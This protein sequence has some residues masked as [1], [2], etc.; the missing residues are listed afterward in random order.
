MKSHSKRQLKI[1]LDKL[2]RSE[3]YPLLDQQSSLISQPYDRFLAFSEVF[4]F[5]KVFDF[6]E[7]FAFPEV[8]ALHSFTVHTQLSERS[9]T[10]G[11]VVP[12][13]TLTARWTL[14][15]CCCSAAP[16]PA[17]AAWPRCSSSRSPPRC[18]QPLPVCASPS[19]SPPRAFFS[20]SSVCFGTTP[21]T[22]WFWLLLMKD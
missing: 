7:V 14:P 2:V 4:A 5:P 18:P 15:G 12:A 19:P 17:A 8:S 3:N 20:T 22:G 13:T 6:P 16:A 9:P 10:P 21:E 11:S 1:K